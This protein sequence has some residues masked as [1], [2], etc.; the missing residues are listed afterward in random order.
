[1]LLESS[2]VHLENI[3]GTGITH[4]DHHLQWSYFIVQATAGNTNKGARLNTVDLLI[5]VACFVKR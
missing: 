4:D 1:M 3:Y 5:T 2:I